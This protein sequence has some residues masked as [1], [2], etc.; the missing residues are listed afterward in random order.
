[1]H[2]RCRRGCRRRLS[3]CTIRELRWQGS[4]AQKDQM[5]K[6]AAEKKAMADKIKGGKK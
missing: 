4:L 1:M 3:A 2:D 6:A 5:K